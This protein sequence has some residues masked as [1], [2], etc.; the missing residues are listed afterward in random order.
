M[1]GYI[2]AGAWT[3]VVVMLVSIVAVVMTEETFGKNLDYIEQ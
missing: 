1:V 2:N 3:G